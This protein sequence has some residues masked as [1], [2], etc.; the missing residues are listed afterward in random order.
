MLQQ[1]YTNVM[2]SMVEL[3]KDIARLTR[4]NFESIVP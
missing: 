4:R 2:R 1:W 3:M